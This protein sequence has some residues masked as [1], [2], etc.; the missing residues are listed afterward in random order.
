MKSDDNSFT[1]NQTAEEY[2]KDFIYHYFKPHTII[3]GYDHRFGKNR[4]GD[5][6]L[7]EKMGAEL[8]FTVTEIDEQILN[9]VT[10]SSTKIRHALLEHD[11]P[12]ANK[13]LGYPYFFEGTVVKGNQLGRTI[14]Y[15]TANIYIGNEE[16]L[17][18]ENGVYAVTVNGQNQ[19]YELQ[20]PLFFHQ[21]L[22][23]NQY[24]SCLLN[25]WLLTV[26]R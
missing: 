7:L 23:V 12:T 4:L 11:I 13:F 25:C 18:P 26:D 15:P 6:H 8:G 1:A 10:V 22:G 24:S 20:S 16:K 21:L 19:K 9:K 17:I 5:Y 2:C 3:I 14:G